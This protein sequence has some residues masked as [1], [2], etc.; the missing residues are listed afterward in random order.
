VYV[1][2]YMYIPSLE[3][4]PSSGTS[5]NTAAPHV[6]RTHLDTRRRS[7]SL[8]RTRAASAAVVACRCAASPF[9]QAQPEPNSPSSCLPWPTSGSSPALPHVLTRAALADAKPPL[10]ASIT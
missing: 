2:I 10:P 5:C 3:P 7:L 8:T 1:C 6:Q 4:R 9:P